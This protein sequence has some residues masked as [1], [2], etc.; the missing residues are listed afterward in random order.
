MCTDTVRALAPERAAAVE[1]KH[2]VALLAQ[3]PAFVGRNEVVVAAEVQDAVDHE[4]GYFAVQGLPDAGGVA[5]GV[6]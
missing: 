4:E 2:E 6:R 1:K 5:L 3:H